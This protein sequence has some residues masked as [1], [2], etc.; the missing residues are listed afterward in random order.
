MP[1]R[2]YDDLTQRLPKVLEPRY[3][4]LYF[5]N[6]TLVPTDTDLIPGAREVAYESFTE[7]GDADFIEDAAANFPVVNISVEEDRYPVFMVGAGFPMSLQDERAYQSASRL[8]T[9][10]MLDRFQRRMQAARNA[11]AQRINRLIAAGRQA[12]RF[13]GTMGNESV[14]I[15]STTFNPYTADFNGLVDFN[16]SLIEGMTDNLVT[17]EPTTFLV[18]SDY[19]KRLMSVMNVNGTR[20]VY[21]YIK[22]LY[23]SLDIRKIKETNDDFLTR[24]G[25]GHTAGH[26]R[27]ML[28]PNESTV[29]HRHIESSIA[30][31]APEDYIR[32]D[33]E[34]LRKI[35]PMFSCVT[36]TIFDY[37]QDCKYISI[38][39]R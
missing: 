2:L 37:P 20:S 31:L 22:E 25:V 7:F 8:S 14:P 19:I 38:P 36:P 11:I 3:E 39:K 18:N 17:L 28:Y 4:Q 9:T 24:N 15:E 26:D 10:T 5:E 35:Y 30:Q 16:V 32:V 34:S 13:A 12:L 33:S 23:P 29:L 1:T 21:S 27:F 6:G